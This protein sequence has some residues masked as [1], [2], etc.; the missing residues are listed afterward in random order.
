MCP[1]SKWFSADCD[2]EFKEAQTAKITLND[3]D[4][5]TV[6]RMLIYLYIRD[7]PDREIPVTQKPSELH[8][9]PRPP[10]LRV[11]AHSISD[12]SANTTN[13]NA[14]EHKSMNNIM[15]YAIADKYEL[16]D[17]KRLAKNKL[18]ESTNYIS[19]NKEFAEMAR[20]VF[21]TPPDHDMGLLEES[22][23]CI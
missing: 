10:H 23:T 15:V 2:G 20:A 18:L 16:P 1:R 12:K 5:F 14:S 6:N 19:S 13:S 9:P 3:D 4:P 22:S 7:Y 8:G 17:L 11:Y 21:S